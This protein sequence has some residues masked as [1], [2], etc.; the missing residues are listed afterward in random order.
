MTT[1]RNL[2]SM[3]LRTVIFMKCPSCGDL[4]SRVTDTR[5]IEDGS[6]T[7]RR[8]LCATCSARFITYERLKNVPL[9]VIKRNGEREI[10]E[11]GKIMAGVMRSCNK[12]HVS[13]EQMERLVADVESECF[14]SGKK[15]IESAQIGELVMKYLKDLDQVSYVRF[16]SVYK[17]FRDIDTFMKEIAG[18]LQEK[19]D[20]TY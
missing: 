1:L 17:Q 6:V 18:L 4:D 14:N 19:K 20:T 11:S 13:V 7:R 15:E 2:D 9:S 12:R 8:R 5:L 10:F 3:A 16:A